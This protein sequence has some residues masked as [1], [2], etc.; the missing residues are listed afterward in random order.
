MHAIPSDIGKIIKLIA[1]ID[2]VIELDVAPII[3]ILSTDSNVVF[4]VL[5]FSSLFWFMVFVFEVRNH[6]FNVVNW[7]IKT[8][9]II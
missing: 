6:F 5:Y 4:R 7:V 8:I 9:Y 2:R 3:T 1:V